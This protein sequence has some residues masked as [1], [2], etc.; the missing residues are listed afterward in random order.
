M[1]STALFLLWWKREGTVASATLPVGLKRQQS[2]YEI[3]VANSIVF[4]VVGLRLGLYN[5]AAR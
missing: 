2:N 5:G 1:K 3:M 4:A